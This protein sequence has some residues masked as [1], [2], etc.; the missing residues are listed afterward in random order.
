MSPVTPRQNFSC[1]IECDSDS[2]EEFY[3]EI[4]VRGKDQHAV[5]FVNLSTKV[6]ELK[7]SLETRFGIPSNLQILFDENNKFRLEDNHI[8]RDYDVSKNS[9]FWVLGPSL[10]F[11]LKMS[12]FETIIPISIYNFKSLFE[13]KEIIGEKMGIPVEKQVFI[14]E[15]NILSN[16]EVT[17]KDSGIQ[18]NSTVHV[19]FKSG[20][21]PE[22]EFKV[23]FEGEFEE[24]FEITVKSWN[25][26]LD[27]KTMIESKTA[28]PITLQKLVLGTK[29]I[30]NWR[31]VGDCNITDNSVIDLMSFKSWIRVYVT[32]SNGNMVEKL[33]SKTRDTYTVDD[34]MDAIS[35]KMESS[36]VG[37]PAL[38]CNGIRLKENKFL[39][40][41]NIMPGTFLTL[42]RLIQITVTIPSGEI[43]VVD[44]APLY[45]IREVKVKIEEKC[46]IPWEIQRLTYLDD[47][48]D[49]D[50]TLEDYEC[51]LKNLWVLRWLCG[52]VSYSFYMPS[53]GGM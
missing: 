53:Y 21:D 18:M 6:E 14:Y 41:Y 33:L 28:F 43:V 32:S 47:E 23:T 25:T 9:V 17:L 5:M 46:G 2:T 24:A 7:A 38:F 3:Y 31:K 36:I 15:G 8:M 20:N 44:L 48:I 29:E 12:E 4:D 26:G 30:K 49:E 51:H 19:L 10:K 42:D 13:V 50:Y 45:T 16:N 34:L 52:G 40:D 11:Y 37:H 27:I 22:K 39:A 1:P 35:E